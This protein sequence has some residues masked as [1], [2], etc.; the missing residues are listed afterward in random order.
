MQSSLR[1][2]PAAL[3]GRCSAPSG[4]RGALVVRASSGGQDAD[5]QPLPQVPKQRRR[6]RRKEKP[7]EQPFTIDTLNPVTSEQGYPIINL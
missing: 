6:S 3:A 5:D 4:R 7:V 2:A 1:P